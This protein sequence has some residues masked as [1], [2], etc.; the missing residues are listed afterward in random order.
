M[1]IINISGHEKQKPQSNDLS[2][3]LVI[4]LLIF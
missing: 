1:Y 4:Y 2:I 3:E